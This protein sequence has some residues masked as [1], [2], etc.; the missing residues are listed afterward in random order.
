MHETFFLRTQGQN[1]GATRH[2]QCVF[3]GKSGLR[4]LLTLRTPRIWSDGAD[5]EGGEEHI[6]VVMIGKIG[7]KAERGTDGILAM[8]KEVEEDM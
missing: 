8:I 4:A 5:H 3:N 7:E 2:S 6:A 1:P